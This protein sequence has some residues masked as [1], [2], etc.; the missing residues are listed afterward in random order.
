MSSILIFDGGTTLTRAALYTPDRTLV[1]EAM[2]EACNPIEYGVGPCVSTLTT[3]A[4]RMVHEPLGVVAAGISGAGRA[5]IRN[6]IARL[7][8]QLLDTDRVRVSNDLHP[9][10]FANERGKASVLAISG[11]GSSVMAQAPDGRTALVGG[12]GRLFGDE[13]SAYQIA[14]SALRAAAAAVDGLGPKTAL[15]EELLAAAQQK[16]FADLVPWAASATK[17]SVAA[18]ANT[19]DALASRGDA[20]AMECVVRQAEALAAQTA[21][22][23]ERL[24]LPKDA[25][26]HLNGAVFEQSSLFRNTYEAALDRH[27]LLA[28]PAFP[29]LRG[30]RAIL[31]L[32]LT[33]PPLPEWV[34][35]AMR[36]SRHS[37]DLPLTE[38]RLLHSAPL[39]K[40]STMEIVRL[41]NE[42]DAHISGIVARQATK[43]TVA[44][45]AATRAL[46]SGGR[47][48]YV[49]AGTSGRLGVL[50]GVAPDRVLA[51]IAGGDAAL[52]SSA[53]GAEDDTALAV[54]DLR[55][56][57]P[58]VGENDIVVGISASGKTPYVLA[59]LEEAESRCTATVLVC[60]NYVE[61]PPIRIIIPLETGP[62]VLP[63]ST[64]LKAG[65]ATKLV[66]NMISTGALTQAGYVFEGLMVGI[67]PI[68][69]KL[70]KRAVRITS[71]LTQLDT[72]EAAPLLEKADGRIPVAVLMARK[73]LNAREAVR[74]LDKAG[75]VLK[76]AL[77]I[78]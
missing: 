29:R 42:E 48:I 57:T 54:A 39:D 38:Q 32:A 41:M 59:A 34:S 35:E 55:A 21:A 64:R 75:G 18:L 53:E 3:L 26:V 60:S 2:A 51:I 30:H 76:Y 27:G 61:G 19:V 9:L 72:E 73:K 28:H 7:L 74:R 14:V 66:L 56:L 15:V 5:E 78:E 37:E 71:L 20:V 50:V 11:T 33:E 47:L 22:A 4:K 43:I 40:S 62:E 36:Y 13:G 58:P 10:L 49:G 31:E 69:A 16:A 23:V 12:R 77:K 46:L 63:G 68:N 70:R 44:I 65:T 45:E 24:A 8:C 52:R 67:R 17:Q 25:A 1:S 6:E